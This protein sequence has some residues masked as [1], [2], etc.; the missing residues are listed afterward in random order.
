MGGGVDPVV[1]AFATDAN[2]ANMMDNN[3]CNN[4]I[5]APTRGAKRVRKI[6]RNMT[7]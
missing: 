2:D 3:A 7:T 6:F 4:C 1:C 5:F